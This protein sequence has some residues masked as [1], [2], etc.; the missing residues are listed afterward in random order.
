MASVKQ[1]PRS[2]PARKGGRGLKRTEA[3]LPATKCV[4][5]RP[6][7]RAWIETPM[8][9]AGSTGAAASPARKGGRGLKR[10]NNTALADQGSS[11]ARKGGRGLKQP[12]LRVCNQ[13]FSRIARPQGRA[14]IETA[15]AVV[16]LAGQRPSPARKG[17]RGLKLVDTA[18]RLMGAVHRPPA[19]A[20]VD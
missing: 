16:G 1:S 15:S 5:A 18:D 10:R 14:W 11:P 9:L 19:R 7:G 13:Q 20:G 4:I 3:R 2:S 8:E 6:Q 12:C 17:G